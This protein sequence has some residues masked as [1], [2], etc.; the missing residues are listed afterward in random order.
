MS[1]IVVRTSGEP[2]AMAP[3]LRKAIWAGDPDQPITKIESLNDMIEDNIWRPRFSAWV[4]TVLGGLA[5]V[6]NS[7]GIY[8]VVSF[9]A[10]LQ[11]REV[12]IRVALGATPC[13]VVAETLRGAMLPLACGLSLSLMAALL[14]SRLLTS[15]LYEITNTDPAAYGIAVLVLQA[16]DSGEYPASMEG[17]RAGS[18]AGTS[19][20]L[21]RGVRSTRTGPLSLASQ[22]LL[23]FQL[24]FGGHEL[25]SGI[26]AREQE[27]PQQHR[28]RDQP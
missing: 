3:A 16:Q 9:T 26:D 19:D 24:G 27:G 14:L 6:L 18:V 23:R 12:G 7:A 4:F 20:G 17:G 8:S 10:T 2:V 25:A 28:R 22:F 11:A 5:L 21:S 13:D 1:T 15:L